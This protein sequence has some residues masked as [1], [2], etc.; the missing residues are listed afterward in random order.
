MLSLHAGAKPLEML[1]A[2]WPDLR[3]IV[4]ALQPGYVFVHRYIRSVPRV[5]D[6]YRTDAFVNGIFVVDARAVRL[7]RPPLIEQDFLVQWRDGRV[8]EVSYYSG[9]PRRLRSVR[10]EVWQNI[11]DFCPDFGSGGQY[12]CPTLDHHY[13]GLDDPHL[14]REDPWPTFFQDA[15]ERALAAEL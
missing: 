8:P 11:A 15:M 10:P 14:P 9:I 3:N 2:E 13:S 5:G 7:G 1:V 6:A 12:R 4:K